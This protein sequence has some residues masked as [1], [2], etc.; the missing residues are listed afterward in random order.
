MRDADRYK[1]LYGPYHAPRCRLGKKLL[2][3]RRGWVRVT[4]MSSGP[5][6][7]PMTTER[8]GKAFILCGDL[9]RAVRRESSVAVCYWWGVTPQT[10][11]V[12][13]RVLG[14]PRLNEG[15]GLLHKLH[16]AENLTP[17][18]TARAVRA[19]HTPEAIARRTEKRRGQPMHPNARKGLEAN[20]VKKHTE[21]T[22]RKMSETH[23]QRGTMPP[24]LR[25]WT[26][27]ELALL[28]TIPDREL[29]ARTG[30]TISAIESKRSVLKNGWKRRRPSTK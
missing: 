10:V 15:S 16:A 7:W 14:V 13:R 27:E 23:R 24:G 5:I 28:G 21:A 18:V 26:A 22:R 9:A 3:K 30:R 19:S 11:T 4:R 20:R 17:E 29:A 1:L 8:R 12:W 2:C 6:Q 25:P